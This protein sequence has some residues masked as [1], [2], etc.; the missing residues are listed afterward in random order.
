M[1]ETIGNRINKH[2]KEKGLTQE[3]LAARLSI[4]SQAVSK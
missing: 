1:N 2:R 4:S 3:E